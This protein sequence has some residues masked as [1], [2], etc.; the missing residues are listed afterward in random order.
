MIQRAFFRSSRFL[1]SSPR[2][3]IYALPQRISRLG[4][5]QIGLKDAPRIA[6][7]RF[8]SA[9]SEEPRVD[10]EAEEKGKDTVLEEKADDPAAKE[11]EAKSKEIIDLKVS[12]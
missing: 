8:Y 11:L 6:S 4:S 3:S 9:T 1:S 12:V 2:V 7:T 5:P 10:V